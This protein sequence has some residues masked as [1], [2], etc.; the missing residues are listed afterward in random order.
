MEKQ[1]SKPLGIV[2]IAIFSA[3]SG[4]MS[5]FGSFLSL[6]LLGIP[7]VSVFGYLFGMLFTVHAVFSFAAVYGL[8]ALERW[9][10]RLAF[11]LYVFAIPLGIAAIFPIFPGDQFTT[12]NTVFQ[13]VLI[14]IDAGIIWYLG[15]VE[16]AVL[17][18]AL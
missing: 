9:G 7:G 14:A 4:L 1:N 2:L 13:L 10:L 12:A 17:Y 15:R 5:L 8:W 3:L 18:D 16:I 6:F 11:W